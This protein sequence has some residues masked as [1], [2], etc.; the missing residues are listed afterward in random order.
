MGK[1]TERKFLVKNGKW[2]DIPS[3]SSHEITQG[4]LSVDPERSVRIRISDN[5]AWIT[6][7]GKTIGFTRSEFEYE[8]PFTEAEIILNSFEIPILKKKRHKLPQGKHIWEIDVFENVNAPLIIAEIELKD[9]S[10]DFE[11]PEWLGEEVTHDPKYYNLA[12]AL[13]PYNTW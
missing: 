5:K 4:Y 6:I 7:K 11:M 3:I 10:E 2:R 12:L 9:E 13:K 8:I 1:E